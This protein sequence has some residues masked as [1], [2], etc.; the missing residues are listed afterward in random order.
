MSPSIAILDD[1]QKAL[2]IEPGN[3][4]VFLNSGVAWLFK[5]EPDRALGCLDEAIRLDPKSGSSG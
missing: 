5:G 2:A 4:R 3:A 1:Y